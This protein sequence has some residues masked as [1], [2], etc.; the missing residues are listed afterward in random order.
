MTADESEKTTRRERIDRRLR[1][2]GWE[3]I[4]PFEHTKPLADYGQAAVTE[5]ATESGPAG[6]ALCSDGQ[7]L[8]AGEA[9]RLGLNPEGVLDQA[10]RYSRGMTRTESRYPEGYRV[11]FLYSSNGELIW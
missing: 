10:R 1:L 4:V 5:F 2:S 11:P 3:R 6:Y 7:I 8:G 9:K